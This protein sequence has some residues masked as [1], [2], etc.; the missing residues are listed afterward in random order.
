VPLF[1]ILINDT[2]LLSEWQLYQGT[3][4]EGT[5]V[6]LLLFGAAAS[7]MFAL[8]AQIGEQVDF[9]RFL[10]EKTAANKVSW[11]VGLRMDRNRRR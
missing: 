1:F 5:G 4:Q 6:N 7:V 11:W 8:V 10:P 2:N 9:L 3:K